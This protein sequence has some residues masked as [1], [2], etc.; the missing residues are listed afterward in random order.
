MVDK[1]SAT[2]TTKPVRTRTKVQTITVTPEQAINFLNRITTALERA[3]AAIPSISQNYIA[4]SQAIERS[5]HGAASGSV[6]TAAKAH[7]SDSLD[8]MILT[9][10]DDAQS[11]YAIAR[12]LRGRLYGDPPPCEE[13]APQALSRGITKDAMSQ[14]HDTILAIR[15]EI[16]AIGDYLV[17]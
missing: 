16:L 5:A 15:S 1:K 2:A 12:E 9:A 14:M 13:S 4:D 6:N 8:S 3:E 11:V 17:S 10:R 7:K